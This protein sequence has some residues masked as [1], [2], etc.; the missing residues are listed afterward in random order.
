[1]GENPF[2]FAGG[3]RNLDVLIT[4]DGDVI[5]KLNL[6]GRVNTPVNLFFMYSRV[7]EGDVDDASIGSVV[8]R[9]GRA[10]F[11]GTDSIT[12]IEFNSRIPF[13]R[14]QVGVALMSGFTLGPINQSSKNFGQ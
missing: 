13:Q 4:Q 1:V 12:H 5:Y 11:N 8:N 2:L 10:T 9:T 6:R 3:V 14:F 7:G